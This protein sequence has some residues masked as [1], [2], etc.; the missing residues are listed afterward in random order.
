MKASIITI[1][2]CSLL[3]VVSCSKPSNTASSGGKGG[4]AVLSIIPEHHGGYVD[5][6]MVYIKYGTNDAPANGI[7]DDS[8]KCVMNDTIPVAIFSGLKVG[9]YYLF[10]VGLHPPYLPPNVKG[11][12]PCP[13]QIEDSIQI[14]LPTFTYTP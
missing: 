13:I 8:T 14:Y 2:C 1:L 9:S 3:M 12:I 4:K 5:T 7:Y 10:A 6:C 11:G